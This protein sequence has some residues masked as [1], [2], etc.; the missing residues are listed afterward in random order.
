MLNIGDLRIPSRL[1]LS[2]MAGVSTFPFRMFNRKFGCKF[3]FL[4]MINC[5][6][7]GFSNR[8]TK[9]MMHSSGEDRPLGV[10][11]FGSKEEYVERA[12]NSVR[13]YPM[14]LLDFNAACPQ[15]KVVRRGEGAAL[16]KNPKKLNKLLKIFVKYSRWPVT[17]KIRT[18]WDNS[19]SVKE[20]ACRAED[21]GIKALFIHGRTKEHGYRQ[22]VD[23]K[24]IQKVKKELSIPVI[25]SGDIFNYGLA[26]KMFDETGC[27]GL[28]VARGSFGNPWIFNE[29]EQGLKTGRPSPRP[30]MR[31]IVKT[32][33]EHFKFTCDFYGEKKG[34]NDFKK[35]FIWYTRSLPNVRP[36]RH[37][38][39]YLKSA[40]DMA[41]L[42]DEVLCA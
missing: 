24:A 9:K 15:K 6:S 30:D 29:I 40:S 18:G 23:Y 7:L 1:I 13:D 32:M 28:L 14:D 42:I 17:V 33:K 26:K 8:K 27:D 20:I 11:L 35:F 37:K 12:V 4:E 19:S 36:L 22:G 34:I 38:V 5:R 21:S 10:Q 3:C 41:G 31:T 25:A 16:L 39:A 2:P